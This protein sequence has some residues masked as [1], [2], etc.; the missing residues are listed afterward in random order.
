MASSG[1]IQFTDKLEK[2]HIE[3]FVAIAFFFLSLECRIR[4]TIKCLRI[5]SN[6][7]N[8]YVLYFYLALLSFGVRTSLT[9]INGCAFGSSMPLP[10]IF[11]P[12][13]FIQSAVLHEHESLWYPPTKCA[14]TCQIV[15]CFDAKSG[16]H[17][18]VFFC[19][20]AKALYTAKLLF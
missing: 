10:F 20:V 6:I 2:Q 12:I 3:L 11:S 9:V 17:C 1:L 13:E 4:G 7:F 8:P 16:L 19:V 5:Y 18:D 15:H 14:K